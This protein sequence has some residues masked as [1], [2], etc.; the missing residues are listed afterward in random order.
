MGDTIVCGEAAAEGFHID[1][2][3]GVMDVVVHDVRARSHGANAATAESC[4]RHVVAPDHGVVP[5]HLDP[6]APVPESADALHQVAAAGPHVGPVPRDAV[7]VHGHADAEALEGTVAHGD[8][9][10]EVRFVVVGED[11]VRDSGGCRIGGRPVQ[12]GS[13]QIQDDVVRSDVDES[14]DVADDA[15][16]E[17]VG[18]W[19]S[20]PKSART[21]WL[22]R[23][24]TGEGIARGPSSAASPG[25]RPHLAHF[26]QHAG[27]R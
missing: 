21:N 13:V 7:A 8:I 25:Q 24:D 16:I 11:A 1:A 18:P 15:G 10:Y 20:W 22:E 19:L 9:P 27:T 2:D 26:D 14:G 5:D 12:G 6:N 3:V 4:A 17:F 23:V